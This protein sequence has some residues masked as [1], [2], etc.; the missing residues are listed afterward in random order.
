MATAQL[1]SS[2]F[3]GAAVVGRRRAAPAAS[4]VRV[5]AQAVDTKAEHKASTR[6][7]VR[8]PTPPLPAGP[9]WRPALPRGAGF[10][11]CEGR[12]APEGCWQDGGC[13]VT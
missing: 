10:L 12:E 7:K 8:C 9:S 4:A 2:A 6:P 11:L 13:W 5:T 3:L 1:A